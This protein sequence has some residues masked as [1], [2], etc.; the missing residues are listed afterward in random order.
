MP[1]YTP[2]TWVDDDGSGTV[3]T[4]ITAARMNAIEAAVEDAAVSIDAPVPIDAAPPVD[5][6]GVLDQVKGIGRCKV[7]TDCTLSNDQQS[8]CTRTCDS[9]AISAKLQAARDASSSCE[10][11]RASG[12]L[13]PPPAPC[14]K[15]THRTVAATCV[16]GA[17]TTVRERLAP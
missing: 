17:C 2:T 16:R 14:P 11:F 10:A 6:S 13:C 1:D 3:G 9:Y 5:S 15:P 7:D 12:K 4:V 8:C